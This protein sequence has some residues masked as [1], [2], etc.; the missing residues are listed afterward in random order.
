VTPALTLFTVPGIPLVQPGD[1][2]ATLITTSLRDATLSLESSDVLVV[3]SK[4]VSKAE[5]RRLNLRTVTPSARAEEIARNTGKDPRL[6]EVVLSESSDV[7]RTGNNVLITRHRLGFVSAN[8]GIDHSN[9]GPDGEEWVL[10]L[11][12]DP[13]A[14]ARRIRSAL[15][16]DFGSAPALIISDTHGRPHRLGN[17]SVAI[18][19]AG[20][21]A[22]LNLR[23]QPD[24]F[25][26]ALQYTEIGLADEIASAADLLSGQAAEG[27]P[28]TVVR[29]LRFPAIDGHATD[30]VRPPHLDLYK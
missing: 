22:L 18:G 27:L 11:P 23:G 30:L 7:S 17:V 25:G 19:V 24:L 3:T 12:L 1:D 8:G 15:E 29:G 20:L 2:I 14:S 13:D 4:I 6:V 16:R 21:P 26:R 10:L 9:V 5:G 28:V